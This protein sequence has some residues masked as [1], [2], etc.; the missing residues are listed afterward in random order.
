MTLATLIAT[1]SMLAGAFSTPGIPTCPDLSTSQHS[2][3]QELAAR[4]D[5]F[6]QQFTPENRLSGVLLVADPEGIVLHKAYGFANREHNVANRLDSRMNIA[7]VTKEMTK[8]VLLQLLIEEELTLATSVSEYLPDFPRGDEITVE[9]LLRFRAGLPH[10]VTT[11]GESIRPMTAEEVTQRAAHD[12]REHGLLNEPGLESS[13]SSATYS[14]LARVIEQVEEDVFSNILDER[15]FSV[16][17]MCSTLDDTGMN[18]IMENRAS[19]YVPGNGE[20]WNADLQDASFLVGAGSVRSTA[21]DLYLFAQALRDST[22]FDPQ[23]AGYLSGGD[24]FHFTGA[25]NG[26]HTWLDESTEDGTIAVFVG[27]SWGM[28]VGQLRGAIQAMLAGEEPTIVPIPSLIAPPEDLHPYVGSYQI[29]PGATM[30]VEVIDSELV[31]AGSVVLPI[32]ADR[33]FHQGWSAEVGFTRD[34]SGRVKALEQ[35]FGDWQRTLSKIGR[36]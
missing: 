27:N 1:I 11:P 9:H 15:V 34:A 29:R 4:I 16:S 18:R 5:A 17:E 33:F 32:G 19:S 2:R 22:K 6:D 35:D 10:R 20:I 23:I 25:T 3:S 28:S 21:Y 31:V 24:D 12:V 13:Y 36:E 7:S 26:F 14:V 30:R 8:A